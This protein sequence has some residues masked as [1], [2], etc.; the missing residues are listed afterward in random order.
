MAPFTATPADVLRRSAFFGGH[1]QASLDGPV[2]AGRR[3]PDGRAEVSGEG[4]NTVGV[5]NLSA[6]ADRGRALAELPRLPRC[7]GA[8]M[9]RV[10]YDG[11]PLR[12]P[13]AVTSPASY[14][15]ASAVR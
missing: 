9:A 10:V 1:S 7:A 2:Q 6:V 13:R 14:R 3:E 12:G 4:D 5:T 15:H 8:A 11:P